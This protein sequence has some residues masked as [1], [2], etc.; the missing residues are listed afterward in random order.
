MASAGGTPV[1]GQLIKGGVEGV[2]DGER[3]W[4]RRKGRLGVHGVGPVVQGV[5]GA[6]CGHVCTV[7]SV[8][9]GGGTG[10]FFATHRQ[11]VEVPGPSRS[12]TRLPKPR[13]VV[14]D[15]PRKRQTR[16]SILDGAG[17]NICP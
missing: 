12:L 5:G 9:L 8:V 3:D 16:N 14:F 10:G 17:R 7:V 15:L 6:K 13:P 2:G 11:V 4:D 1:R